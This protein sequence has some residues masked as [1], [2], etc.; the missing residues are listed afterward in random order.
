MADERPTGYLSEA[1]EAAL[2][3]VSTATLTSQ[4]L[5]RGFR[6]TFL[7]GVEA[8]RPDLRMVGYA[9]TLRFVPMREDL[10]IDRTVDNRTSPQRISIESVGPKDVLV[11]DARGEVGSGTIGDILATRMKVRGAVGVVT[12][13]A[14]RDRSGMQATGLPSYARATHGAASPTKHHP[15]DINQPIGC[16]GV[17]VMPGDVVVGDADGVVVIPRAVAEEVAM[18]ALDQE[19]VE[20]FVLTKIQGGSSIIGVYPPGDET[21]AEFEAHRRKS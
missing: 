10:D 1:A 20:A 15:A 18:A 11:M 6:N 2:H 8:L 9:F 13:G 14:L 12:D 21:R 19:E 17:L 16:A 5:K 7:T 4:L 3:K